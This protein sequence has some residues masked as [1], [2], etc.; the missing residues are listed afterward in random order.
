MRRNPFRKRALHGGTVAQASSRVP[1]RRPGN[2]HLLAQMKV[3]KAKGLKTTFVQSAWPVTDALF[4]A[5]WSSTRFLLDPSSL[6]DFMDRKALGRAQRQSA[7]ESRAAPS[8][9]AQDFASREG[10]H[11]LFA[12]LLHQESSQP[13]EANSNRQDYEAAKRRAHAK[14][15]RF[16]SLGLRKSGA[17]TQQ[18]FGQMCVEAL[19]FG[20]FHLG[21]Q[22]KVTRPPGRDPATVRVNRPSNGSPAT[23]QDS[24]HG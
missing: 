1:A 3:T 4:A 22:M 19:C 14:R 17:L 18:T 23:K 6:R 24:S 20:D 9:K 10:V 2:F 5:P 13:S 8:R 7:I 11:A 12:Q 21:Q 15:K 16:G